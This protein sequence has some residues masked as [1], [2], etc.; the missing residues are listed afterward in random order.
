MN[1]I[2]EE[3]SLISVSCRSSLGSV[4]S[5]VTNDNTMSQ[6]IP[7]SRPYKFIKNCYNLGGD[8]HT[9]TIESLDKELVSTC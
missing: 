4:L 9:K 8:S 2:S 6:A 5:T 3:S 7:E 1:F